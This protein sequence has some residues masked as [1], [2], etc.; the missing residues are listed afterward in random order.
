MRTPCILTLVA[1]TAGLAAAPRAQTDVEYVFSDNDY[2]NVSTNEVESGFGNAVAAADLSTGVLRATAE[3]TGIGHAL[4]TAEIWRTFVLDGPTGTYTLSAD[5]AWNGDMD[6]LG[7]ADAKLRATLL[8]AGAGERMTGHESHGSVSGSWSDDHGKRITFLAPLDNGETYDLLL[9]LE[10][11]VDAQ[12][13]NPGNASVDFHTAPYLVDLNW[14]RVFRAATHVTTQ[15]GTK[16]DYDDPVDLDAVLW[17]EEFDRA[18]QLDFSIANN[19][20]DIKAWI[21]W[22]SHFDVASSSL[23]APRV[24]DVSA[25]NQIV[26]RG[27]SVEFDTT[28]WVNSW[29]SGRLADVIWTDADAVVG[30]AVPDHSWAIGA[31]IPVP[32]APG[33][34]EHVITFTNEDATY[35]LRLSGIRAS[36]IASPV[37]VPGSFLFDGPVFDMDLAASASGTVVLT[38]T[39]SFL[40]GRIVLQYDVADTEGA[41][42]VLNAWGQHEVTEERP[43]AYLGH[44]KGGT[45]GEP[46]LVGSGPLSAGSSNSLDLVNAYP[47]SPAAMFMSFSNNPTP[48]K[49]GVLVPIPPLPV[50][51][52]ATLADGTVVLPFLVPPGIPPGVALYMQWA[53]ADPG[54]TKGVELSNAVSA[55]FP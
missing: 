23:K 52:L 15:G 39:G 26:D 7:L 41:Q 21:A 48:F 16:D 10:A 27:W 28:H 49:G 33:L 45:F 5:F 25:W 11:E 8:I 6:W 31:A 29:N 19:D 53:I 22:I 18:S 2:T 47:S 4:A 46:V 51:V 36:A 35:P 32:G 37:A 34:Y 55:T 42:D 12:P 9:R 3:T 1:L 13:T 14:L 17:Q 20:A 50:N 38:T 44:E 24:V 30:Q 43:W 54:A 40:G